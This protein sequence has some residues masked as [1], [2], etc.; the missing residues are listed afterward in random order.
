[1]K[2]EEQ[3]EAEKLATVA[4]GFS[5]HI[6]E[7][8]NLTQKVLAGVWQQLEADLD[9]ITVGGKELDVADYNYIVTGVC[10]GLMSTHFG[11]VVHGKYLSKDF[12]KDNIMTSFKEWYL[13]A[14]D[15]YLTILEKE[16]E[17]VQRSGEEIP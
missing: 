17:N 9:E 14:F 8:Q 7:V 13:K 15:E 6:A 3:L 2:S 12:A 4:S 16:E 1:M 5:K 10:A 11:R